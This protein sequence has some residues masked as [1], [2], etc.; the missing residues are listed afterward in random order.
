[1]MNKIVVEA[2]VEPL[3]VLDQLTTDD[4]I[5]YLMVLDEDGVGRSGLIRSAMY[6]APFNFRTFLTAFEEYGKE[7]RLEDLRKLRDSIKTL[8]SLEVR[9]EV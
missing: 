2:E 1:M 5:A 6:T 3:E 7:F 8:L 9:D 4:L